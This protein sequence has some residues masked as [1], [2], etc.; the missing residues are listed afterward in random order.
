MNM[1]VSSSSSPALHYADVYE[2]LT[3]KLGMHFEDLTKAYEFY[4]VYAKAVGSV[5]EKIQLVKMG[6]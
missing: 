5:Q 2:N 1:H 4:N 3:Q 6:R